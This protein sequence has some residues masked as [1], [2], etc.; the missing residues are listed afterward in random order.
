MIIAST[1]VKHVI[2]QKIVQNIKDKSS[3]IKYENY[4]NY[5]Q[6]KDY[7]YFKD[8]WSKNYASLEISYNYFC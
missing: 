3:F 8:I 5:Y 1:L 7:Q 2:I 6:N 4:L